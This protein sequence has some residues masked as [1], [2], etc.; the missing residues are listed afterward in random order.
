MDRWKSLGGK[1]MVLGGDEK[2]MVHGQVNLN[3][4][5]TSL[6]KGL[7]GKLSR[8]PD[9]KFKWT[10]RRGICALE[11]Q[12]YLRKNS[13]FYAATPLWWS[14]GEVTGKCERGHRSNGSFGLFRVRQCSDL[15]FYILG[16]SHNSDLFFITDLFLLNSHSLHMHRDM[17][18]KKQGWP[19]PMV[20]YDWQGTWCVVFNPTTNNKQLQ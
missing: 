17:K 10:T 13:H 3:W 11:G 5:I 2:V 14:M 4:Q 18:T 6:L 9:G 15:H 20:A 1:V 12:C 16:F 7:D 8:R 19:R